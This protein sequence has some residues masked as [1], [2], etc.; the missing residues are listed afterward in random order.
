MEPLRRFGINLEKDKFEQGALYGTAC[1]YA[2]VEKAIADYLRPFKLSP[3]KFNAMMVIKHMG[4]GSGLSQVDVGEHLIVSPS[5]ITR[6]LD[7]LSKDGYIER[8]AQEGDRRVHLVKITKKGSQ[9]LDKVWPGYYERIKRLT[10][11]L[12]KEELQKLSNILIRWFAE[13]DKGV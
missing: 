9:M 8:C 12:T 2:L 1:V 11:Y 10:G 13:L 7:R 5:N 3:A 6:L 4:N